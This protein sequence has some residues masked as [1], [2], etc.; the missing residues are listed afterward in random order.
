MKTTLKLRLNL[1]LVCL[2]SIAILTLSN[3]VWRA[4]ADSAS[5]QTITITPDTLPN[6]S[7]ATTYNQQ[8]TQTGGNGSIAWNI[9]EGTLPEGISLQSS[10]G[11]LSGEPRATGT[12]NFTVK[13]MDAK[14]VIG[15]KTYAWTINCPSFSITPTTFPMAKTGEFY[16]QLFNASTNTSINLLTERKAALVPAPPPNFKY[17]LIGTLPIGLTFFSYLT[18][19]PGKA[20]NAIQGTPTETGTFHFT[21]QAIP[22]GNTDTSCSTSQNY[23]LIVQEGSPLTQWAKIEDS[24][25]CTGPGSIVTVMASVKNSTANS[26]L[27]SL[28]STLNTSLL[29]LPGT[30]TAD[31]GACVILN[32]SAV[33]WR[34][35]LAA[36]KTA[37]IHYKAQ[38]IDQALTGATICARTS[39]VVGGNL[40]GDQTACKRITCPT[41]GPGAIPPAIS[42]MSD[43]KAGSV[44]VYNLYTSSTD[45][46]RQ[47]TRINLTNSHAQ[48]SAYVHL[49]FVAEGCSV[50]D[51]YLCLTANQ[52]TSFLASDLDPNTTGYLVAVAVDLQG[53]PTNFNYLAGDEYVKLATGHAANLSAQ[54]FAA[55]AGGSSLC[56]ATATTA[57]LSFDGI[58]YNQIPQTLAGSSMGSKADGNDT[59]LIINRIGGNLGTGAATLGTLFGV[60]YDDAETPLSFSLAG[61]CQLRGSLTN[62]F[63]RTT[64]RFESFIPA[65]RTGWLKLFSQ[66]ADVGILGSL[67]NFNANAANVAGAFNQGHN[68]HALTFSATNT[69]IIP[70]FPPGC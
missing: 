63:P 40:A 61:S 21:I 24:Q 49:F 67:I 36:G 37:T 17:S 56:D 23:T 44:L 52:T 69:I 70:V 41:I 66:E 4:R 65:G 50:A 48:L 33:T 46:T 34:G 25:A 13:A 15:V 57:T 68:L 55:I 9:S 30:C 10:T 58:S 20:I 60:F 54:A 6:P 2:I 62:N 12:F 14:A 59:L 11:I 32:A 45:P 39:S 38:V 42:E 26:Q 35:S 5:A 1:F 29:A 51:S 47:N 64:P 3:S 28:Q 16:N 8:L 19:A 31:V 18:V 27:S 53:C 22:N 7:F 43:Q